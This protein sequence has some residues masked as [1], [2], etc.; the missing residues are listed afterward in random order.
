MCVFFLWE[1]E[2]MGFVGLEKFRFFVINF[3]FPMK[4]L[5][6]LFCSSGT[7]EALL[8]LA[9]RM[10]ERGGGGG[11]G[12]NDGIEGGS[13]RQHRWKTKAVS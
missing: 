12:E 3:T 5:F 1:E 4:T 10:R 8:L 7:D 11:G 6:S 9:K 13:A 2:E